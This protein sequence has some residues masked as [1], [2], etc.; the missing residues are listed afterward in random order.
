M[1]EIFGTLGPACQSPDVLEKMFL[2]GMTGIRL[3]MSHSGLKNSEKLLEH[4]RLAARRANISP[5]LLIDLQG[6]EIRVG[7]LDQP[8]V[9]EKAASVYLRSQETLAPWNLET[10][11]C[12]TM[13]SWN[14][15]SIP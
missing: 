15:P 10:I 2:E 9:L 6:P 12:W 11:S 8:F 4:Y 5:E 13:G 3:N 7:L 14:L 1:L